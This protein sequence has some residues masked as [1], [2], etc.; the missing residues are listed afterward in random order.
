MPLGQSH[1][2]LGSEPRNGNE[3]GL[4]GFE[5]KRRPT[6]AITGVTPVV[7]RA[8]QPDGSA[9]GRFYSTSLLPGSL[10]SYKGIVEEKNRCHGRLPK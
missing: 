5:K 3:L 10:E 2:I 4:L 7:K 9:P 6:V 8:Q 1:V